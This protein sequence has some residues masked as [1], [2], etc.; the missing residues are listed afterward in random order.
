MTGETQEIALSVK[1]WVGT[2]FVAAMGA[3][4]NVV[5]VIIGQVEA[6]DTVG[7]AIPGL[8]NLGAV[9]VLAWLAWHITTK[10]QPKL[11]EDAQKERTSL[12]TAFMDSQSTLME[13]HA[14]HIREIMDQVHL[15]RQ[16]KA[17]AI[18]ELADQVERLSGAL[19]NSCKT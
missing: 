3:L 12:I 10:G 9:G 14:K 16:E 7:K 4:Q 13:A 11:L 17:A 5:P 15:D 1:L 19:S 8:T 18:R 6:P 2:A